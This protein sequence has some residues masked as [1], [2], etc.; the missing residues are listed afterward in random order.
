MVINFNQIK[1]KN[2]KH[3]DANHS[4]DI[5]WDWDNQCHD[6]SH[7]LIECTCSKCNVTRKFKFTS[8]W[9]LIEK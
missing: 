3:K 6:G 5:D 9:E 1:C 8:G 2:P 4:I 7:Y